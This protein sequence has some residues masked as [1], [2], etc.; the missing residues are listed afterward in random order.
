MF[1]IVKFNSSVAKKVKEIWNT[2]V[3]NGDIYEKEYTG[4]YCIG[5]ESYLLE[6][7]LVDGKCTD[8]PNTELQVMSEKNYFLILINTV[9][10]FWSG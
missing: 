3:K 1:G 5:C 7:D 9:L 6:K 8:H 10:N 2:F 4:K